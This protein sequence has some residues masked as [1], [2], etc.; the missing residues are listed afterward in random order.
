MIIT[1]LEDMLEAVIE[2]TELSCPERKVRIHALRMA[3]ESIRD[4]SDLEQKAKLCETQ[5]NIF[6]SQ[7]DK[8]TNKLDELHTELQNLKQERER[9]KNKIKREKIKIAFW[10]TRLDEAN[11]KYDTAVTINK[12]LRK[13]NNELRDLLRNVDG[14]VDQTGLY[15]LFKDGSSTFVNYGKEYEDTDALFNVFNA[16]GYKIAEFYKDDVR[17]IIRWK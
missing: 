9:L 3:I 5:A 6:K 4:D 17:G 14:F 8:L 11:A 7:R 1:R 12:D 15:V 16:S 13:E 10:L 2:Q